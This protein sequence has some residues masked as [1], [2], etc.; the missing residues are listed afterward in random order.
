M[1]RL[2]G[3]PTY[4]LIALS[5]LFAAANSDTYAS[6]SRNDS[7]LRQWLVG[8]WVMEGKKCSDSINIYFENGR[9][10][11]GPAAK[12]F[13]VEGTYDL[14]GDTLTTTIRPTAAYRY[15]DPSM[16]KY[17]APLTDTVRIVRTSDDQM[18][19]RFVGN[20]GPG[21]R[22]LPMRRCPETAGPEPWFPKVKYPGVSAIRAR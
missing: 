9:V 3:N 7:T 15:T 2:M 16:L 17:N 21:M 22:M 19:F 6:S 12:G 10:I 11:S 20:A 1:P 14:K 8:G 4:T 13:Q 5:I 18:D